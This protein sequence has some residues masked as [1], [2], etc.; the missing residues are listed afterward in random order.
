MKKYGGKH[1]IDI[2][3]NERSMTKAN[4]CILMTQMCVSLN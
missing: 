1:T 4:I 3:I 2:Q